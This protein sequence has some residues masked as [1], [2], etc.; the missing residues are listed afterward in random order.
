MTAT[1]TTEPAAFDHIE[2]IVI[3]GQPTDI[4]YHRFANKLF[5]IITQHQKVANVYTVRSHAHN[6]LSG[7]GPGG[8]AGADGSNRIYTIK[9]T[10]GASSD[11]AEAAIRYLMSFLQQSDEI[12][13]T[14]GLRRIDKAT[15]DQIGAQL[16]KIVLG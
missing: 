2:T 10:F 6:D 9:H 16:R 14:L 3:E 1:S 7:D 15:L 5:L 8:A 13:I 12:V 4:V 11:E